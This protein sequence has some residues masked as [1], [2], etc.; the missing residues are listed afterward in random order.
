VYVP[1]WIHR[2]D[3][4]SALGARKRHV[5]LNR[6][7]SGIYFDDAWWLAT[8]QHLPSPANLHSLS[9]IDVRALVRHSLQRGLL[10][11]Q[12]APYAFGGAALRQC[13]TGETLQTTPELGR[14]G[15]FATRQD[16]RTAPAN[17]SAQADSDT[18]LQLRHGACSKRSCRRR[19]SPAEVTTV[20]NWRCSR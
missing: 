19:A 2:S 1:Y 11:E 12:T 10:A 6:A 8:R 3:L 5:S 7:A 13:A 17:S 20:T 16:L 15:R 14:A 9:S 18:F 4:E